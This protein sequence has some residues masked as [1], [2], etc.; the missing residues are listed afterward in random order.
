MRNTLAGP[1]DGQRNADFFP[2]PCQKVNF[3]AERNSKIRTHFSGGLT[4][5][6]KSLL[7]WLMIVGTLMI[8]P[9]CGGGGGGSGPTPPPPATAVLTLSTSITGSI[10]SSTTINGYDVTITLPAGVTVKASPDGVNPSILMVD[11][12]VITATSSASVLA[13]YTAAFGGIPAKVKLNLVSAS[14]LSA[15]DFCTVTCDI[16]AGTSVNASNFLSIL[17]EATGWDA[18]RSNVNLTGQLSLGS[19]VAIH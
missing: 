19:T 11:P 7:N 17:N 14:G 13:S 1:R 5:K 4:M 9:H 12:G 16:A 8:L 15:G 10:P 18:S 2:W 3:I 6:K